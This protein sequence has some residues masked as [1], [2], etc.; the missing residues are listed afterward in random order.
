MGISVSILFFFKFGVVVFKVVVV[1]DFKIE[2]V[3]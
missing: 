1:I 3:I 2:V